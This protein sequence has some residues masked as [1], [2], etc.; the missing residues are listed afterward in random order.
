[1]TRNRFR[2]LVLILSA[3]ALLGVVSPAAAAT[4]ACAT[5]WGSLAKSVHPNDPGRNFVHDIRAG[6]HACY[7]RV[8]IDIA[9][10][11]GFESYS[12]RYVPQV[13]MDGSGAV[14]PLRGGAKL[15][16][17]IGA[18]GYDDDGDPTYT[19]A[20]PRE[21]VGVAGFSTLRQVA[22]LGSYEGRS[23]VGIGTR[24]RLPFRVFVLEGGS[25]HVDRLVIDVAHRW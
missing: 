14:V 5:P 10:V 2:I 1:M 20:V 19:P 9:E 11:E 15:Q 25:S 24:A 12:V 17:T 6:K 22:W 21:A 3:L 18:T 13:R 23:D 8:V 7:D 4:N 16:V